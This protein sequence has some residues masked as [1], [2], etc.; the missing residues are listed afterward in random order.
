MTR[1]LAEAENY[2]ASQ[3]RQLGARFLHNPVA[4]FRGLGF[5]LDYVDGDVLARESH[6][7]IVGQC[8]PVARRA[9]VAAN[10]PQAEVNMTIAHE[11][12]H[13]LRLDEDLEGNDKEM[14]CEAFATSFC[15][16]PPTDEQ[17][18]RAKWENWQH[19]RNLAI[20]RANA[21]AARLR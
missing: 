10:R 8:V 12:A 7:V 15:R 13:L 5:A 20:G 1:N 2:A 21:R 14:I 9:W 6:Q 18:N 11:L 19:Q 4:A 16:R 3:G 17:L